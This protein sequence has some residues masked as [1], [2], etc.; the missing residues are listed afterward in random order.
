MTWVGNPIKKQSYVTS[1]HTYVYMSVCLYM[2]IYVYINT[3][4]LGQYWG[5]PV[6]NLAGFGTGSLP[7]ERPGQC[8]LQDLLEQQRKLL[9]L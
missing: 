4:H 5:F 1:L 2:S 3:Q 6:Y 7:A 9:D 8:Y